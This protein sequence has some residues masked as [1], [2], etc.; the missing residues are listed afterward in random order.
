MN[1]SK[2]DRKHTEGFYTNEDIVTI[3]EL[4]SREC[5]FCSSLLGSVGEKGAFHIDHL[6]P[7]SKGGSNW[8]NNICLTCERCNKR[9]HSHPTTVLWAKLRKEKGI[10]W[11]K[12]KVMV[13]KKN[14]P[15]K[16]KISILRKGERNQSLLQFKQ[17]IE[18]A[19]RRSSRRLGYILPEE[20]YIDVEHN[21]TYLNICFNNTTVL[22]PAPTQK[23]LETWHF[24]EFDTIAASLLNLEH[25]SGY[26][27]NV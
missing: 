15:A 13:N 24:E 17:E 12:H 14:L 2:F 16:R 11:V 4:Q 8:P 1:F 5:Y 9:K 7:I 26:L 20:T 3:H 6:N 10:E 22:I 23:K 27:K 25:V 19:I 21:S 18:V